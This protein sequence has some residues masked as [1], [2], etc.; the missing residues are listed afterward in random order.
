MFPIIRNKEGVVM[1]K[2]HWLGTGLSAI[3][4]LKMLIENDHSV[5]VY[6]RTVEKA[7]E[8]LL[9][10]KGDYQIVEFSLEAIKQNAIAGDVVVS[11]LPGNFHVP[12]AE[13]SL[14]LGAHFVSSSYISDEMKILHEE[15]LN[16]NLC[17][18]NEVGLDPGIDHS[19]SHALVE[20]YKNSNI[21]SIENNHSFLSYCGGL[22]DVPND[23]CY[24][25]SWSPLGVLKAL[26]STSVSIR[27]SQTYTV[28]KPWEA[29]EL[30]PLPMPWGE[31]EFEVYPNRDS[32][33]FIDQYQMNEGLNIDQFVRGTLRYKGWK[34]AWSDIFTEVDSLDPQIA[35]ERL[36]FIS[37][38]LWNKY[39]YRDNEVDRVILTVELK[40]KSKSEVVWHKQF[41]LDTLGNNK[42]SA[43]AQL[44]SCSVALAVEAVL[45]N[46]IPPGVTAAPHQSK[47]V[48]RWLNQ[49]DEISDHFVLIDH[50]G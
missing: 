37:D 46:E 25:F 12:V 5:I 26:M 9:G 35:E 44:V 13:L 15:S 3:P 11:M 49:A 10:I 45:N 28:H 30:Y 40:V 34:N 17:L 24:K 38:D 18:V 50:L 39:S 22:S 31:D 7:S 21:F 4:G 23:F 8:A 42:G 32:L 33:P 6:N 19:M 43:M 47:L 48:K 36:K 14:S 16:K 29:V 20:E 2:I 41:L 1:S 27:D